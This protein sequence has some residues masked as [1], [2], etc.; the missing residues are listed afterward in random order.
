MASLKNLKIHEFTTANPLESLWSPEGDL[1]T[2]KVETLSR[3]YAYAIS[4]QPVST[5]FDSDSKAFDLTYISME[6][7]NHPT[8]IYFN[9][10]QY[11]SGVVAEATPGKMFLSYQIS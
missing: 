1:E 10:D 4:G 8:E 3:T 5:N 11:S 2:N 6:G 7:E 9:P